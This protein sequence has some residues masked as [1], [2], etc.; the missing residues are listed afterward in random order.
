MPITS[1]GYN[2]SINETQ[3]A[4]M[5]P[6]LSMPYW[7]ADTDSLA[8]SID[9]NADR[10]IKIAPGPFGGQGI[11]DTLDAEERVQFD[12]VPSK[13]RYDLLVARRDWR[14]EG[15]TTKFEVI[16]GGTSKAIPN[17]TRSPGVLDD[18]LIGLIE[19]KAGQTKPASITDLRGFGLNS[20]V[21]ILDALAL[22]GYNNH[23]GMQAQLGREIYNLQVD[24][25]WVRTGL[26]SATTPRYRLR[27][28]K[29]H[30]MKSTNTAVTVKGGWSTAGDNTMGIVVQSNGMLKVTKAGM[31]AI[32]YSISRYNSPI[33]VS[34]ASVTLAIGGVWTHP[35]FEEHRNSNWQGVEST[36]FWSGILNAGDVIDP[37]AGQW[38]AKK[39]TLEY[40]V[41]MQI[42][43]VG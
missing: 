43:M 3:W 4:I 19:L 15:G 6:R 36:M 38:N 18:Q 11:M 35:M 24:R 10:T 5:A 31:Y 39:Q 22:E 27:V 9:K 2:G 14:G 16:P 7:V 26:I 21:Q 17:F 42:E 40:R 13:T 8:M 37:R 33:K 34:D 29:N 25:T 12:P 23:P 41:E 1:V 28:A 30:K 20:R 32:T